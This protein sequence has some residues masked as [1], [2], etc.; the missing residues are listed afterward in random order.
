[1][2]SSFWI[3][4]AGIAETSD[5]SA[6]ARLICDQRIGEHLLDPGEFCASPT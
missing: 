3:G 4:W 1:M 6:S 2:I 5:G